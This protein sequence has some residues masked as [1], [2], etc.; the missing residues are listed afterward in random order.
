MICSYQGCSSKCHQF[1]ISNGPSWT[2]AWNWDFIFSI[3]ANTHPEKC[4]DF[5]FSVVAIYYREIEIILDI[6]MVIAIDSEL[7]NIEGY[8]N[9]T[10]PFFEQWTLL[11]N[12]TFMYVTADISDEWCNKMIKQCDKTASQRLKEIVASPKMIKIQM[13]E[14][15]L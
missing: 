14:I 15:H 7:G 10:I 13:V 3:D 9:W 8:N 2:M 11:E 1:G 4:G 12:Y 6:N 5:Y